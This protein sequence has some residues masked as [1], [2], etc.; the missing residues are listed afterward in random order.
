MRWY[1]VSLVGT[2]IAASIGLVLIILNTTPDTAGGGVKALF[3]FT[4]ILSSGSVFALLVYFMYENFY[5]N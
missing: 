3:F 4:L 2:A 1:V 5:S